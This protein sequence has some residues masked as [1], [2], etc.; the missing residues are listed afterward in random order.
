MIGIAM[1]I[2]PI[3]T[4]LGLSVIVVWAWSRWRRRDKKADAFI[5][6][7]TVSPDAAKEN[8]VEPPAQIEVPVT[9]TQATQQPNPGALPEVASDSA[10]A[11]HSEFQP[12]LL[13]SRN[14]VSEQ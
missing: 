12:I 2:F 13:D 10:A 14:T 7:S 5:L 4:L 8:V 3:I 9:Q 1:T 11:I 6:P